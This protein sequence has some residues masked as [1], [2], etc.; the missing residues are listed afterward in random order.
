MLLTAPLFITWASA[1][2][3]ATLNGQ[4]RWVHW[5]GAVGLGAALAASSAL[6]FRVYTGAPIEV[7][8]GNWPQGIGIRLRADVLSM[9]FATLSDVLLLAALLY[10]PPGKVEERS[11]PA[12]VLFL[13]AGLNGLFLTGDIFDFY[14][15]FEV[16]MT[17]SYILT[18]YGSNKRILR[19]TFSFVIVNLLGSS[20]FLTGVLAL[21]HQTGTLDMQQVATRI[22]DIDPQTALLTGVLI[23]VAFSIKLGLFPFQYWL[24]PVYRGVKPVTAAILGGILVNIGSY[25]LLRFGG[26]IFPAQ[27]QAGS[28][29]LL[30]LGAASMIYGAVLAIGRRT[31]QEVL[32]YSSISQ[33]GY[34]L[35]AVS[36][37]GLLGFSTAIVY[38]IVNGLNKTMLFL[39]SGVRGWLIS[40]AFAVGALS[41][42]GIPP[43][44]GFF[45]K[46]ALFR[47]AIYNH[48]PVFVVLV[49][50]GGALS[51]VY[52]F[53][54]YQRK[55]WG[56]STE[57]VEEASFIRQYVIVALALIILALGV[58]PDPLLSIG[59]QWMA[60]GLLR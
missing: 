15:F 24:P 39:A 48:S 45:A 7:V 58:W 33:A 40:F 22:A 59:R 37:G 12:L 30:V 52:M 28:K 20:I 35:I 9:T 26:T 56:D 23:L 31:P 46:A 36:F 29:V 3:L 19:N 38:A 51:F 17:S 50:L 32:A 55:F 14:V 25:G 1:A 16:S 10:E 21:Y 43:T 8:T 60:S 11:F 13:A 57:Q 54:I 41:V 42:V 5:A 47:T 49:L 4:R 2:L 6:L 53:Q 34:I 18:S 44:V 27:L